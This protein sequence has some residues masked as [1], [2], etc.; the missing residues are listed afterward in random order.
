LVEPLPAH[1][2]A[3]VNFPRPT[4]VKELLGF[5]GMVNF[6]CWFLPGAAKVLKL[7]TD[8]L[9]GGPKGTTIIRAD[10]FPTHNS[11]LAYDVV[12]AVATIFLQEPEGGVNIVPRAQ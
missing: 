3:V 6:Y 4:T 11:K 8:C 5:L 12:T 9:R 7:L 1:V 10:S 2:A